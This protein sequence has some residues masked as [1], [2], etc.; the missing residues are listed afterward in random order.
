MSHELPNDWRQQISKLIIKIKETLPE[1]NIRS[2][3]LKKLKISTH[4]YMW[5]VDSRHAKPNIKLKC[6]F[7]FAKKTEILGVEN[8]VSDVI[9]ALG[10][11]GTEV[12][13]AEFIEAVTLN[14]VSIN[15]TYCSDI[16]QR[17]LQ[18]VILRFGESVRLSEDPRKVLRVLEELANKLEDQNSR[19][20][21]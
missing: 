13:V 2:K 20:Q 14:S 4:T 17:R 7:E 18:V 3:F 16:N 1:L 11:N 15:D 9:K 8:A 6:L 10:I 5:L 21:D 12:E 19:R